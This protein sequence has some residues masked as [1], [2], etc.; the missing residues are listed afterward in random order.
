MKLLA[1]SVAAALAALVLREVAI[2]GLVWVIAR[3]FVRR[4]RPDGEA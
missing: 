3:T 4:G 1:A 2:E